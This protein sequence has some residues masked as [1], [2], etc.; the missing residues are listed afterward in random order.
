MRPG[1]DA[2]VAAAVGALAGARGLAVRAVHRGATAP[3]PSA[4]VEV[5]RVTR[6]GEAG[7]RR[8]KRGPGGTDHPVR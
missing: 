3:M 2:E 6:E 7:G 4:A 8:V 1:A 5:G